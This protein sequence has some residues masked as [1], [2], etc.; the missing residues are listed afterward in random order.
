MIIRSEDEIRVQQEDKRAIGT[1]ILI[2]GVFL[3]FAIM[4]A[5]ASVPGRRGTG[6]LAAA[7][8]VAVGAALAMSEL[9]NRDF[10]VIRP[11]EVGYSRRF[12]ET[13]WVPRRAFAQ[14]KVHLNM[15]GP[16]VMLLDADNRV[17]RRLV[18]PHLTV[19]EL[20]N[21]FEEGGYELTTEGF[22]FG[23]PADGSSGAV[24]R[25]RQ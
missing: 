1:S 17:V 14:V 12:R 2:G 16:D 18:F 23:R 4:F 9:R 22:R 8:F 25:A 13:E 6:Y 10:V 11:E 19:K 5:F 20:R 21:A 15:F 24:K 3:F 7:V